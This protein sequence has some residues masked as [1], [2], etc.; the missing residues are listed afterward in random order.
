[1]HHQIQQAVKP[2]VNLNEVM[3]NWCEIKR[4]LAE[5][6]RRRKPQLGAGNNN[7]LPS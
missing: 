3:K 6:S 2:K 1:M 4:N 5:N 7:K